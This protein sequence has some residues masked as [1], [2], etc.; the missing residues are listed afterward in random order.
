MITRDEYER[1]FGKVSDTEWE[2][3]Q[4]SIRDAISDA[5]DRIYEEEHPLDD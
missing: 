4:K 3:V 2:K 5:M 1:Y